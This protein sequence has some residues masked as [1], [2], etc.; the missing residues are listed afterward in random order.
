MESEMKQEKYKKNFQSLWRKK[1][2]CATTISFEYGRRDIRHN[3]TQRRDSQ[4]HRSQNGK[5]IGA[6]PISRFDK[7]KAS[8]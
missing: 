1:T 3:D 2:F 7:V 4:N 5:K 8:K 6:H